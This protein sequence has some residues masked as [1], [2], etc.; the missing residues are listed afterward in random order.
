MICVDGHERPVGGVQHQERRGHGRIAGVG[1]LDV[2]GRRD[3][4]EVDGARHNQSVSRRG[5]AGEH[6]KAPGSSRVPAGAVDANGIGPDRNA[7]GGEVRG[8]LRRQIERR[9]QGLAE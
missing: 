8:H 2:E 7:A 3:F 5:C 1:V 9:S 6:L 4:P